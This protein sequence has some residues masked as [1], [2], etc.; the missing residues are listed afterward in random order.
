ME[1]KFNVLG[2]GTPIRDASLKV[3]GRKV[4]VD[5]MKL[6]GML[7]A[8]VLFSPHAHAKIISIDTTKASQLKGVRAIATHMNTPD[9]RY[10]SALRF[11]EHDIPKTERIFDD[12]VRFVGDRVAAVAADTAEIAA[13]AI[14]LIE[15]EYEELPAVFDS[16]EAM[17]EGAV[18]IHGD[19]NIVGTS[20]VEAGDIEA[21]FKAA[22]HIFE[23]TFTTPAIH[24]GAIETHVAIA[25]Y[26]HDNKL[27]VFTPCQNS[28]GFRCIFSDLFDLPYN[29]VRINSPAIGGGFGG[30]LEVTLE[31]VAAVLSKMCRKPVKLVYNRRETM[32]ST[33]VRHASRSRVRIGVTN[34][35]RLTAVDMDMTHNT[36]A[37]AS[38]ALNVL[39]ASSH[40]V[41]KLYQV[42]NMRFQGRTVYTNTPVAGA[43]RG[44]GSPQAFF[45]IE[46]LM[47]RISMSLGIDPVTLYRSNL[48][49][50]D[51]L[52][53]KF[54][55]PIGNPRP[56]DCLEKAIA[57]FGLE[58][59]LAEAKASS[60]DRYKIGVGMAAGLHGNSC[61]GAH[62]DVTT[63]MVKMNE[64][65]S[66]ILYTGAHDMGN[67]NVGAQMAIV[68]EVA[69]LSLDKI[70]AVEAD[71]D[72]CLWHLGDYASRGVFVV[73]Q[74]AYKVASKLKEE[75]KI[76]AAKLLQTTP[77]NIEISNN[78]AC[79]ISEPDKQVSVKE[80]MKN[81]QK[82]SMREICVSETH[83]AASGPY[84]YGFH[85]AMVS[86]DTQT[87]KTQVLKYAAVH[88]VGRALNPMA[89]EG[90]LAG[91]IQMG[92]GY[93]LYEGMKVD[94]KGKTLTSTLKRFNMMNASQMPELLLGFIE[95][96][97]DGGPFGAKSLGESPVVPA[98]PAVVN[99]VSNAIGY[100]IN[101]LPANE[102]RILA[103]FNKK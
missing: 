44:Y 94:E 71:T 49:K 91:G 80:V 46:R 47:N 48:V 62:R 97:E 100:E 6:P 28:F 82:N 37:Y 57:D 68:A 21:G 2:K 9:K 65:G 56:L 30:K 70:D 75:L 33:R 43:M 36:G 14:G 58:K 12:R 55:S 92:I 4:Y 10:N 3:T 41:F 20:D 52:D 69:G 25:D 85:I 86:V 23:E 54:K 61:F 89:L 98:G 22:D 88:D 72:A 78:M 38:S 64:D 17:A 103:V 101:D 29:K 83:A 5:D 93:G 77:D 24:H 19:S 76:E 81:C 39:G 50:P 15:V 7:Y 27:T 16:L 79:L 90:Q 99:A 8:K 51:S 32:I 13:K 18:P 34:E 35:G 45:G 73:G 40:K 66:A 84:S 74:A 1:E 31:P 63:L 95:E 11:I 60:N 87:G 102:E 67:D 96:G 53:P 42:E 59:A 26:R